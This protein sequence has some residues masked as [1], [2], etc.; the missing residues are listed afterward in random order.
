MKQ[1]SVLFGYLNRI[2]SPSNKTLLKTDAMPLDNENIQIR[3]NDN[4][5]NNEN[6]IQHLNTIPSRIDPFEHAHSMQMI[7]NN[8]NQ[9]NQNVTVI[10]SQQNLN[11]NNITGLQIGN[12]FHVSSSRKNSHSRSNENKRNSRMKKSL[13]GK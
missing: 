3:S 6:T 13:I 2:V 4:E 9:A 7:Q 10:E 5:S 1:K 11:F 8:L 12:T